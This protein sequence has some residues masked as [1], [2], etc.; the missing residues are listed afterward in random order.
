MRN[1]VQSRKLQPWVYKSCVGMLKT[2]LSGDHY[3]VAVSRKWLNGI[4]QQQQKNIECLTWEHLFEFIESCWK[5]KYK[6]WTRW[7]GGIICLSSITGAW[8]VCILD[9]LETS[10]ILNV[11]QENLQNSFYLYWVVDSFDRMFMKQGIVSLNIL[12]QCLLEEKVT[13][14]F[15]LNFKHKLFQCYFVYQQIYNIINL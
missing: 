11:Y 14:S 3:T 5:S 7:T 13:N 2:E 15:C 8:L 9:T 6:Y 10:S 12:I 4:W 1:T